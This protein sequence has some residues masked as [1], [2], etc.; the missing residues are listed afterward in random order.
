MAALE[1]LRGLSVWLEIDSKVWEEANVLGQKAK[2]S[3]LNCPMSDVLINACAK[4]YDAALIYRD[5]H[6]DALR[7]L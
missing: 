2:R 5:R 1:E 7:K 3:G 6:F 4:R